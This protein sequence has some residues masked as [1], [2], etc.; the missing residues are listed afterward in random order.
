MVKTNKFS[1]NFSPLFRQHLVKS[2]EGAGK[3]QFLPLFSA[4][5]IDMC[6]AGC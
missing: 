3:F 1:I 5:F 4:N 6:A 2:G